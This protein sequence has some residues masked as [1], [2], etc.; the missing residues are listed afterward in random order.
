MDNLNKIKIMVA[1]MHHQMAMVT[2]ID[3]A[4]A[5]IDVV[6]PA[7]DAIYVKLGY[8][9]ELIAQIEEGLK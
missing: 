5:V 8:V 7:L 2:D 9:S 4:N 1:D 6:R 3:D